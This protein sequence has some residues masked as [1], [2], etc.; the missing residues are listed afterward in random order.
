MKKFDYI[1]T[2]PAGIHA[3]PAG[4]LAKAASVYKSSITIERDGKVANVKRILELMALGVER[5]EKVSFTIEG[6][7]EDLAVEELD[8]LCKENL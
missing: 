7:D 8:T 1:I 4:M 6:T 2:D 3:R 5:D